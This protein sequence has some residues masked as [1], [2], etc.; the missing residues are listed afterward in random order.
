MSTPINA[1]FRAR[2]TF[3]I[4]LPSMPPA[5]REDWCLALCSKLQEKDGFEAASVQLPGLKLKLSYDA[6]QQQLGDLLQWLAVQG[7]TP[8][9]GWWNRFRIGMALQVDANILANAR[10]QPHCCNKAPK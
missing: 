6:S 7:V 3:R 8:A 4:Q 2:H 10:H 9:S 5:M 1:G